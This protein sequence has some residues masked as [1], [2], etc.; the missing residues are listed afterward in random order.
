MMQ[1][2][3]QTRTRVRMQ[4]RGAVQGVGFRPFVYRLATELGVGGWVLNGPGGVTLEAE[5][6]AGVVERFVVRLRCELPPAAAIHELREE[7]LEPAGYDRF[8]IRVSERAGK[9]TAVVLPDLATCDDCLREVL[10]RAGRR[11]GYPFTNCTRC[12]PRFSIIR[13]LPYDR[14]N[15]TMAGFAMCPACGAEYADPADRRFHAQPNACP[16]CGPRLALWDADGAVLSAGHT[17]G[18]IQAAAGALEAGRVVAVKG[19]GGFHLMAD[20]R[21]RA[22]VALLR[23]RKHRPRKPLAVMVRDVEMARTLCAVGEEAEALLAGPE[24]PIVLL[25]RLGDAPVAANLAPGNPTLGVMLP[26]T[27][28]HHLLL[29]ACGFPVVATSG[30]L[31][32]EPICTDEHEAV[33]RLRGIADLFVVHDRPIERHVDDSVAWVLCGEPRLLRRARGYAPLPVRVS[34]D[35][36]PVLAVGAQLKN[37]VALGMGRQVFVSQHIGDLET[38]ESQAA[39]ERVI[40]DFLRLYDA[41]PAAIAHDLHP[42]YPSTRWAALLAGETADAPRVAVQHHHAHLAS[43]LAENGA[44]GTALGLIW[45]GTGYGPDGTI[46]GGEF[47]AGDARGYVRAAHLLPF[48][49]PGGDAAIREPR[50]SALALLRAAYGEEAFGM[51]TLAPVAAFTPGELRVMAQM[52]ETGFRSTPMTSMGRLFD[53]VAALLGLCQRSGYEGEA[54]MA[55][56]AA[57]DP[58]VHDAYE[59]PVITCAE[60]GLD[61]LDWRPMIRRMVADEWS[62]VRVDEIAARFHNTLAAAAVAV[63]A[64]VGEPRVALSGGCFQNRLLATRTACSLE[65][66]G[67]RVLMHRLVPPNDGGVSLG[68]VAVAAARLG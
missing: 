11:H 56:E 51:G 21:S 24:A 66:A 29:R 9:P 38:A 25:R 65:N 37:T 68:Q 19:L 17:A 46:W 22:A 67:F 62:G 40:A 20:A 48:A 58:H 50:R 47:L 28:L 15:T 13:E 8:E 42:D 1:L 54:A 60:T 64:R 33:T 16:V 52:L 2:A 44:G 49:L 18:I 63:A 12:G 59:M 34:R 61:A 35:L 45:D 53:G 4:I 57:A 30:N 10:D 27:P 43:C 41:H 3:E 55:L 26:S 7:A 39:F 5:G 14:P 36:P 32:E 31:S 23:Q 6:D